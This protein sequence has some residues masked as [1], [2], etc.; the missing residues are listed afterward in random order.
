MCLGFD[1][2]LD[3]EK[4]RIGDNADQWRMARR[5][6]YELSE[7]KGGSDGIRVPRS[8]AYFKLMELL[9]DHPDILK[10]RSGKK[11]APFRVACLAEG[12]GG[13]M[14]ALVDKLK[15]RKYRMHAITLRTDETHTDFINFAKSESKD[16]QIMIHYGSDGSG[17]LYNPSNIQDFTKKVQYSCWLITADGGFDE[18]TIPGGS[19]LAKE[20][21]H[22]KLIFAEMISALLLQATGGHFILKVFDC[23]TL[24][25]AEIIY[26]LRDLYAEVHIVKPQTS[27]PGNSE[28]YLVCK[29]Y[30]GKPKY[31]EHLYSIYRTLCQ[32]D[33]YFCSSILN[34]E[35]PE[36]FTS[37]LFDT[38]R[39]HSERQKDYIRRALEFDKRKI[40]DYQRR[41]QVKSRE[42]LEKYILNVK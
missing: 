15:D 36:S 40:H 16:Q 21:W 7:V 9:H 22:I 24:P 1:Y 4:L 31:L 8:R 28:R 30:G 14:E 2:E 19:I 23:F 27:R 41:N 11:S 35:L 12:P 39:E 20:S 34:V 5:Y 29:R 13:F 25:M 3:E 6:M 42:F 37:W 33:K 10:G 32:Q 18:T 38:N 26:I 17:N